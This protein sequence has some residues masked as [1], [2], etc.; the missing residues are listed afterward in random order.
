VAGFGNSAAEA[1][2]A[3]GD[4][5]GEHSWKHATEEA[6]TD[7]SVRGKRRQDASTHAD[8]DPTAGP[9]LDVGRGGRAGGSLRSAVG[10]FG[11]I[12]LV[13]PLPSPRNEAFLVSGGQSFPLGPSSRPGS[14]TVWPGRAKHLGHVAPWPGVV[15][16]DIHGNPMTIAVVVAS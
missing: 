12:G 13:D 8:R 3:N 9:G 15:V 4:V 2:K 11:V 1:D 7:F 16:G 6:E 5:E 14:A 10:R